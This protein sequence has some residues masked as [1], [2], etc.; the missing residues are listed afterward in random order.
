[1]ARNISPDPTCGRTRSSR[2]PIDACRPVSTNV[3]RQS[4]WSSYRWKYSST[5]DAP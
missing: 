2:S 4:S 3:I 5:A 1:L